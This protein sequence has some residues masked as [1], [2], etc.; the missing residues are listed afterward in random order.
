[1]EGEEMMTANPGET[2]LPYAVV[3]HR[4]G[5]QYRLSIPALDLVCE[6][7]DLAAGFKE[8]ETAAVALLARYR[9]LGEE[10]PVERPLA[11]SHGE[12]PAPPPGRATVS[13]LGA[14]GRDR[15]GTLQ[16]LIGL[17]M[18]VALLAGAV[19]A[20]MAISALRDIGTIARDIGRL[21][22]GATA[23]LDDTVGTGRNFSQ[24]LARVAQTVEQVTPER[25]EQMRR[26]L[27]IIVEKLKPLADELRPLFTGEAMPKERSLEIR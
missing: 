4:E 6:A 17:S 24:N 14:S 12:I 2:T 22:G 18:I 15:S 10:L 16:S 21:T 27:G 13:R 1:M 25:E 5:K 7:E 9:G 19:A 26:D 11:E 23:V 20:V 8:L 3:L